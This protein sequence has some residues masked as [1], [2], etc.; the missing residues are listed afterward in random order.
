[1]IT[2]VEFCPVSRTS[3]VVHWGNIQ[4]AQRWHQSPT[5]NDSTLPAS[6]PARQVSCQLPGELG[7]PC[8]WQACF[9]ISFCKGGAQTVSCLLFY[10]CLLWT[11]SSLVHW[12]KLQIH[13]FLDREE[14]CKYLKENLLGQSSNRKVCKCVWGGGG[15][16]LTHLW[17]LCPSLKKKG[18]WNVIPPPPKL[19]LA[20][21]LWVSFR[22]SHFLLIRVQRKVR[23]AR[24]Q[25]NTKN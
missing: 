20:C 24:L 1:M 25:K 9:G 4:V 5:G 19:S 2:T 3:P 11:V 15:N 10:I 22:E 8:V 7:N 12:R 21:T 18:W 6:P 23:S 16:V 14:P 17:I 13:L